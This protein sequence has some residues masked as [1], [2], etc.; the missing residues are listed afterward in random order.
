MTTRRCAYDV[1][2]YT[3]LLDRSTHTGELHRAREQRMKFH[4]CDPRRFE[5]L[6]RSGSANAIEFLEVLDL[7]RAARRAAPA[8]IVVRLLRPGFPR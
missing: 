6:K 8:D 7:R 5:V 2:A 1:A 4:C 3:V